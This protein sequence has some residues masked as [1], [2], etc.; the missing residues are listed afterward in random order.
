MNFIEVVETERLFKETGFDNTFRL[1]ELPSLSFPKEPNLAL[2]LV[3]CVRVKEKKPYFFKEPSD[4]KQIVLHFTMGHIKGDI[5]TLTGESD[6][7]N[8]QHVSVPFV[9]ARN[10][11]I[12]RLFSSEYWAHHIGASPLG[13]NKA[14]RVAFSRDAIAIELSNYGPLTLGEHGHLHTEY[15]SDKR[16]DIYCH[17]DDVA[18]YIKLEKPYKGYTYYA[19]FTEAQYDSVIVLLRYLT[20]AWGIKRT[21]LP[22]EVRYSLTNKVKGFDGITSHVNYREDKQDIGLAFD[23]D[24]LMNGVL[25]E[26]YTS[27]RHRA[28]RQKSI[29][30]TKSRPIT[31]RDLVSFGGSETSDAFL[32]PDF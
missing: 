19:Q 2:N 26:Q 30:N 21:F 25:A 14:E 27:K 7:P 17:I 20:T 6:D 13:L 9:V 29:E 11:T 18:Q 12:Y 8:R 1:S 4:K 16:T 5:L 3:N 28:L 15:H 31:E 22:E 23:W 10:G 24:R 32:E